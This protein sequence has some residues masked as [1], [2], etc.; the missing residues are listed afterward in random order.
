MLHCSLVSE[1][2]HE[3]GGSLYI[4]MGTVEMVEVS[5]MHPISFIAIEVV[6]RVVL[7]WGCLLT[8][9]L[10]ALSILEWGATIFGVYCSVMA[11]EEVASNKGTSTLCAFEGSFL[12]VCECICQSTPPLKLIYPTVGVSD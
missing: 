11:E 8:R 3:H 12:G 1:I 4:I 7:L 9:P 5:I 2:G 6:W 10:P